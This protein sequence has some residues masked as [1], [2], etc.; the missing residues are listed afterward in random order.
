VTVG[1]ATRR[2]VDAG[3]QRWTIS[4]RCWLE[5]LFATETM[6]EL[7]ARQGRVAD[8][9]AIYRQLVSATD[10]AARVARWKARIAEL[11][12]GGVG[13]SAPASPGASA[14]DKERGA[15]APSEA[16]T[17]EAPIRASAS[18]RAT[19]VIHEPVRSGQVIYAEGR[20]LIVVASVHP[21][22]QLL[23]DGNVHVYGSLKG[24]AVAG[25]HGARDAQVFCLALEAELVGVDTGYTLCDDIPPGL[26]GG[27]A[28]VFL[29]PEG[30]CAVVGLPVGKRSEPA[31]AKP[32]RR[33][34]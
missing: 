24:R 17:A 31:A 34:F 10:D 3:V 4:D 32:A 21:G 11:E 9:V 15:R 14:K 16:M 29:K 1:G 20:D 28:R 12:G 8:A 2:L 33:L 19:L 25:A 13:A 30:T 22:A 23:A 26:R 27:P 7:S 18:P 6:A 5:T